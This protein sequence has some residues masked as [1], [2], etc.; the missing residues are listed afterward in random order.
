[1]RWAE[2]S[3]RSKDLCLVVESAGSGAGIESHCL[4][5]AGLPVV[6]G[7]KVLRLQLQR[8]GNVQRIQGAYA[9]SRAIAAGEVGAGLPGV[10]RKSRPGP[11]PIS[12]IAPKITPDLSRVCR[13]EPLQKYL[14]KDRICQFGAIEFREPHGGA[15]SHA[16]VNARGVRVR[17]VA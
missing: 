6:E 1:M 17:D 9:E 11:D 5:Q 13:G 8:A 12:T 3:L 4:G 10:R 16:R 2:L 14:L 15:A 7:P